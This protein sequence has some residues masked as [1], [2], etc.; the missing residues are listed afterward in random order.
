MASR[1]RADNLVTAGDASTDQQQTGSVFLHSG[2]WDPA[3]YQVAEKAVRI[4][5][6]VYLPT[7][8]V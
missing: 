8:P 6:V 2:F 1:T 4:C 5:R 3:R 7:S